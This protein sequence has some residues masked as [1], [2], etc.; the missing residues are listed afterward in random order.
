[1]SLRITGPYEL[2][3]LG[4]NLAIVKS[5]EYVVEVS[6]EDLFVEKLA[7]EF[8]VFSFNKIEQLTVKEETTYGT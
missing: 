2:L 8:A 6:G 7:E 1:M 3:T 5:G 4:P